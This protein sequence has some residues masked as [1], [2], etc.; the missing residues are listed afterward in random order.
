MSGGSLLS[1]VFLPKSK[2]GDI[3]Q[4]GVSPLPIIKHLYV[5][6]DLSDRLLPCA[7]FPVMNQLVFECTEETFHWGI[8][9]AVSLAAH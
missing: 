5:L 8:V 1:D 9:V 3:S 4:V 6:A 7:K 2:R